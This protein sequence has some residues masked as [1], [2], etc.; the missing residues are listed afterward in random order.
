MTKPVIII[1]YGMGNLGS[2]ANMI[3][4]IGYTSLISSEPSVI[5]KAE[6]IIL[7]GVG[8]FDKAMQNIAS[9]NL[10]EIIRIKAMVEKTAILG[11]CLGMQIMCNK[12]EEGSE[13]G[14]QLVDAEVKKFNFQ[15]VTSLKIPHMGWNG[16]MLKKE[17]ALFLE[18][19]EN[20]RFYFVH[21]YHVTAGNE[22]DVLTTSHYGYDFVSS[23]ARENIM[24]VQFHP[25]KSHKFGMFLL[26]NFLEKF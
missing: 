17:H 22:R 4:Y 5:E 26:K 10:L 1:D 3:R 2:I 21:S 24:G 6:K 13:Q 8:H 15:P 25:E 12:S 9:L 14:L 20:P 7:P 11:I 23:F 18:M 19:P 16:T